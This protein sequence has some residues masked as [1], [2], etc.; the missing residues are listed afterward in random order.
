MGQIEIN[1]TKT[2]TTALASR[3]E[4]HVKLERIREEKKKLK[5][6]EAMPLQTNGRFRFN[7]NGSREFNIHTTK[8]LGLLIKVAGFL[9][10]RKNA[11]ET[12]AEILKISLYPPFT[13]D[14]YS[15]EA[16]MTDLTV[17]ASILSM[18]DRRKKLDNMETKLSGYIT[19]ED[20]LAMDL[21][22]A[23]DLFFD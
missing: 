16:W 11:Y 9:E 12:G 15:Y 3:D 23:D 6:I 1:E 13:W 7:P 21:K 22:A 10:V 17:R 8:E 4:L 18:E 5:T 2:A 14:S 20:K 19:K